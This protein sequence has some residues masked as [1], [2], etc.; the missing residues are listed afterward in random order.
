MQ[1]TEEQQKDFED[2]AKAFQEEYTPL[3]EDLKKKHEVE[4]VHAVATVPSPAGIFGLGVTQQIGD[5]KYKSVPSP[6]EFVAKS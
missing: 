3:Y 5:L 2:R 4:I 6:D 1:Y